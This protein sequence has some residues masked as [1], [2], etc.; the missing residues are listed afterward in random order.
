MSFDAP[1]L[2]VYSLLRVQLPDYT[3]RLCDGGFIDFQGERYLSEDEIFGTVEGIE[4]LSQGDSDSAPGG[5]ITFLAQTV[6]VAAKLSSPGMQSSPVHMWQVRADYLT[7]QPIHSK[8]RFA[9]KIDYTVLKGQLREQK[10]EMG[11]IS[12][13]EYL[14]SKDEGNT[15][16]DQHHQNNYPGELG[17]NNATNISRVVAWGVQSPARTSAGRQ[18][19]E[20]AARRL[21]S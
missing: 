2:L 8:L 14:F 12:D 9:G 4:N 17:F 11:F 21:F 19:V 10:L 1:R 5:S 16:S 7:G 3:I 18:A 20:D 13:G 15:L 6:D